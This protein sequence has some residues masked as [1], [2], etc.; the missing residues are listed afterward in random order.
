M[1]DSITKS[2]TKLFSHASNL[3]TARKERGIVNMMQIAVKGCSEKTE[4][5]CGRITKKTY[6]SLLTS[7]ALTKTGFSLGLQQEFFSFWMTKKRV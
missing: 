7:F 1:P 3:F 6:F 5:E 4:N 2:H